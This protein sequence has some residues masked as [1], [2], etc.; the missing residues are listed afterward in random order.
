MLVVSRSKR[1]NRLFNAVAVLSRGKIAGIIAKVHLAKEGIHYEARW[2]HSWPLGKRASLRVGKEDVPFGN[3]L[4]E[5][6]GLRF[7]IEICEDAWVDT[8]RP[9]ETMD[10]PHLIFNASAS[11]FSLGKAKRRQDLITKSSTQFSTTYAYSNLVGCESGRAI[12]EGELLVGREGAI[13]ARSR[14]FYFHDL[15][16]LT[17]DIPYQPIKDER[18]GAV[19]L[20]IDPKTFTAPIRQHTDRDGSLPEEEFAFAASLG[21]WDYMRKSKHRGFALSLSGGVDK[22]G[23]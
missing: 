3:F 22:V 12:Y 20:H 16:I 14:R 9:A 13:V 23:P 15:N 2:F 17:Y 6:A 21:L 8:D 5:V 11:H 18:G 4:F 10:R 19:E 1:E 7:G